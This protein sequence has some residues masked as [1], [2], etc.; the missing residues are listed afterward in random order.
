[1]CYVPFYGVIVS[2]AKLI[3]LIGD[4]FPDVTYDLHLK[5]RKPI[6]MNGISVPFYLKPIT[7]PWYLKL[8]Q[9]EEGFAESIAYRELINNSEVQVGIGDFEG[10]D[11]AAIF[12]EL[13]NNCPDKELWLKLFDGKQPD[14]L[15]NSSF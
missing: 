14:R 2:T 5:H 7:D 12:Q 8:L 11:S 9:K 3:E 10:Q 4:D 6:T 1:M 15:R 13:L